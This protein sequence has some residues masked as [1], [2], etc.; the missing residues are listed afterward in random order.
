MHI[1]IYIYMYIY[2]EMTGKAHVRNRVPAQPKQIPYVPYFRMCP[3][4]L[5]TIVGNRFVVN[6]LWSNIIR[7]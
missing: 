4:G 3:K 6:C 7:V 1:Y 2:R 5:A